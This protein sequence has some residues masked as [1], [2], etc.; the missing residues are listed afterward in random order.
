MGYPCTHNFKFAKR[1]AKFHKL[2]YS[3]FFHLNFSGN[4]VALKGL[5]YKNLQNAVDVGMAPRPMIPTAVPI[6][7]LGH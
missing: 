5:I 2:L 1:R 7:S 3:N 6:Y 4:L